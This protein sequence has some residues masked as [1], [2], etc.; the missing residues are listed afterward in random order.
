MELNIAQ[1]NRIQLSEL[2]PGDCFYWNDKYWLK[3]NTIS[4]ELSDYT[5]CVRL[6]TGFMNGI[7][8]KANVTPIDVTA[9]IEF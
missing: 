8:N 9:N 3:T 6:D 7:C 2:K 5:K 4:A 1:S